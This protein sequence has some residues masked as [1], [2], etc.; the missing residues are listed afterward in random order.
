MPSAGANTTRTS[1]GSVTVW[2]VVRRPGPNVDHR[3]IRDRGVRAVDRNR[4]A[5]R[6]NEMDFV[7][8]VRLLWHVGG[9]C[10]PVESEAQRGNAKELPIDPG[11]FHV[12]NIEN[13]RHLHILPDADGQ[14]LT[15]R[16][17]NPSIVF[18]QSLPS[19]L[20]KARSA[21]GRPPVWHAGQ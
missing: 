3:A 7:L 18:G 4:T 6:E 10:V 19:N 20:D 14:P 16:F 13:F 12:A 15:N 8:S 1:S 2:K 17:S 11:R 21:S 9:D 5:A